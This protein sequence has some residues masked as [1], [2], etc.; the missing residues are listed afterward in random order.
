MAAAL[1]FAPGG[2]F[3][4]YSSFAPFSHAYN[5]AENEYVLYDT[6]TCY[7]NLVKALSRVKE[8]V[9]EIFDKDSDDIPSK[10][11]VGF[12]RRRLALVRNRV[13]TGCSS[14]RRS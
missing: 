1:S 11:W 13:V 7:T 8:H 12:V 4:I 14:R 3:D 2:V 9:I 6:T 10:T 5:D